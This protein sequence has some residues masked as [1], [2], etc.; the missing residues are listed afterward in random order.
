MVLYVET[1]VNGEPQVWK[2]IEMAVKS[3]GSYGS[4]VESLALSL[5]ADNKISMLNGSIQMCVDR[6]FNKYEVPVFCI[7]E[8]ITYS[9]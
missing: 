1:R 4:K 8:P 6:K 2:I 9:E 5:L 7:N 3:E